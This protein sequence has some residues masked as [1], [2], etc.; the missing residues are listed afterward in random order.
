MPY[1]EDRELALIKNNMLSQQNKLAKAKAKIDATQIGNKL[2][3][4]GE[5]LG[6]GFAVGYV[7]GKGE[8]RATGQW[9]IPGTTIDIESLVVV[10]LA[11]V[12]LAGE[13]LGLKKVQTHAANV[14]AGVG[15]H[16]LG[17]IGRKLAST[18]TFSMVAGAPQVGALPQYDP[19]SYDP[20]QYAA[21]YDDPVAS[22]LS[23]AGV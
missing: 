1:I 6:G 3:T 19:T 7:R 14:C 8:D 4:L 16:Y 18:G 20:T 21:P 23:S 12:A 9:N 13:A 15:G 10:G 2:M 5:G 11:G 22:A 17:Q